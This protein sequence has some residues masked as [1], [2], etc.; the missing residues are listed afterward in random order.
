VTT[1]KDAVKLERFSAPKPP[2]YYL[3]IEVEVAAGE[4]LLWAEVGRA[5]ASFKQP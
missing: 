4:D 2:L 3:P 5:I 1:E